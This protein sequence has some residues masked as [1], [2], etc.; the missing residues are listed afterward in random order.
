MSGFTQTVTATTGSSA[1]QI[2]GTENQD[3]RVHV[4]VIGAT[5]SY[6]GIGFTS[7][8][9]NAADKGLLIYGGANSGGA[10]S[11]ET[12]ILPGDAELWVG[13]SVGATVLVSFLVTE[14]R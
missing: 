13:P 9:V 1:Q 6:V 7:A 4:H 5:S 10:A 11:T 8:E 12:F 3:R 2:G 14:A